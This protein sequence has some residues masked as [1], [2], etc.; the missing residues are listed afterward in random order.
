MDRLKK[1]LLGKKYF[2]CFRSLSSTILGH[3]IFWHLSTNHKSYFKRVRNSM[4]ILAH[5][6]LLAKDILSLK[7]AWYGKFK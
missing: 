5:S 3:L 7:H 2:Y 6:D 4:G 1:A